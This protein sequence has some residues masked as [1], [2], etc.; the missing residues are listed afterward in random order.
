MSILKR[1]R[2]RVGRRC[3]DECQCPSP[4]AHPVMVALATVVFQVAGEVAVRRLLPQDEREHDHA[5]EP[6]EQPPS[7]P[8]RRK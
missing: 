3:D 7:P 4:W 1:P 5:H 6:R 2:V 8:A